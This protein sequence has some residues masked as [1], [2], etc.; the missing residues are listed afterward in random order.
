MKIYGDTIGKGGLFLASLAVIPMNPIN[1][2]ASIAENSKRKE[3][4][5]IAVVHVQMLCTALRNAKDC[6]GNS[7]SQ[8]AGRI[9]LGAGKS[10]RNWDHKD[11]GIATPASSLLFV[12]SRGMYQ[13]FW[14]QNNQH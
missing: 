8:I 7:T 2:L 3:G 9:Q 11:F 4:N 1:S 5:L 13:L 14:C 12:I 6:I 10:L